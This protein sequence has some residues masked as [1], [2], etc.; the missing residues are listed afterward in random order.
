MTL[1]LTLTL[2]RWEN[3]MTPEEKK[4]SRRRR[5][6]KIGQDLFATQAA[7]MGEM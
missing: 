2:T 5:R 6:A 1:T 4:A 7:D 3:Q